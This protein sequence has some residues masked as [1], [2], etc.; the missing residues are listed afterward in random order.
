MWWRRWAEWEW[1]ARANCR[2]SRSSAVAWRHGAVDY[3]H[4]VTVESSTLV[5]WTQRTDIVS[6]VR[7]AMMVG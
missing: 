3:S 6:V 1:R 4:M 5:V 7:T 2:T